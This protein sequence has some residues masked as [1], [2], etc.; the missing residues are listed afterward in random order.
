MWYERQWDNSPSKSQYIKVNPYRSKNGLQHGAL[1]H[2]EQQA[3][4]GPQK[5]LVLNQ[6]NGKTNGLIYIKNEKRETLMNHTNKQCTVLFK[7]IGSL[8]YMK[9]LILIV[10][11]DYLH[12]IF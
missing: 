12:I 1:A 4:K 5:I 8:K 11:S 10:G 7:T 6:S 9:V 2:T 3:I